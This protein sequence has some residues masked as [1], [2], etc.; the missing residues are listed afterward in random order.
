[1]KLH[2]LAVTLDDLV[3]IGAIQV[4][5]EAVRRNQDWGSRV[6]LSQHP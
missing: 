1:M 4:F 2:L 6:E 3:S 5:A